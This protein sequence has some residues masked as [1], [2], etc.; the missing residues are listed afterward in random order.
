MWEYKG[1]EKKENKLDVVTEGYRTR[2]STGIEGESLSY[3]IKLAKFNSARDPSSFRHPR[4]PAIMT[5]PSYRPRIDLAAVIAAQNPQIDLRLDEYERSS[6]SFMNLVAN[7]T[8]KM[9]SSVTEKTNTH[10]SEKTRLNEKIQATKAEINQCKE[11]E[12]ELVEGRRH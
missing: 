10:N 11:A 5:A 8:K 12:I 1:E 4:H 2:T 6:R 3:P 9:T 7:Y